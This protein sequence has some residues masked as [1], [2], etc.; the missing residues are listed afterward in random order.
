M[1]SGRWFFTGDF[2]N[3]LCWLGFH[4]YIKTERHAGKEGLVFEESVCEHCHQIKW[5]IVDSV[6]CVGD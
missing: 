6:G 3:I 4:K 2:M 5:D 1:P